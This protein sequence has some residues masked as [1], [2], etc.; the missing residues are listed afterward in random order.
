MGVGALLMHLAA[1]SA[2]AA[3]LAVQN[4][5]AANNVHIITPDEMMEIGL[6]LGNYSVRQIRGSGRRANVDRFRDKYGSNPL[7]LCQLWEDLQTT[8]NDNARIDPF[9]TDVQKFLSSM[10]WIK[11]HPTELDRTSFC[12]S[13]R[14]TARKY[15]WYF[16]KKTQALKAEKVS[17]FVALALRKHHMKHAQSHCISLD[18]LA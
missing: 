2:V 16:M 6:K 7:A 13:T 5:A 1:C 3:I 15:G 17:A 9:K 8:S 11:K 14:T 10:F 12:K 18:L 4:P